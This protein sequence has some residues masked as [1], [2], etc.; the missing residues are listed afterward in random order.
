MPMIRRHGPCYIFTFNA[1][2]IIGLACN[3]YAVVGVAWAREA[4]GL[5]LGEAKRI[6]ISISIPKFHFNK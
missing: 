4:L 2:E 3:K 1:N 6:P 5:G